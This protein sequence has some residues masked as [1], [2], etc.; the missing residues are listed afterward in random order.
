MSKLAT[1]L[2]S[3]Q[4]KLKARVLTKFAF[5]M[6]QASLSTCMSRLMILPHF[7]ILM[8]AINRGVSFGPMVR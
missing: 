5:G 6:N 4:L 1:F 3:G 2:Q 7:Q 8:R